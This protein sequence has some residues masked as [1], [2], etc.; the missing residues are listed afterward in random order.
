MHDTG[1]GVRRAGA[2][3]AAY[4]TSRGMSRAQTEV[5][6]DLV[7]LAK[8]PQ[9]ML[10]IKMIIMIKRSSQG[11]HYERNILHGGQDAFWCPAR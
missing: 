1:S 5:N 8:H 3:E 4:C 11:V 10:L 6:F 9:S 7:S 2:V